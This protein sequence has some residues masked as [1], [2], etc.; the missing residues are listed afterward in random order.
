MNYDDAVQV[1]IIDG[2]RRFLASDAYKAELLTP[3][4]SRIACPLHTRVWRYMKLEYFHRLLNDEQLY[5]PRVDKLGEPLEGSFCTPAGSDDHAEFRRG[6]M[7]QTFYVSCWHIA[8]HESDMMWGRYLNNVDGVAIHTTVGQLLQMR[9][10]AFEWQGY[11]V[12]PAALVGNVRYVDHADLG[13]FPSNDCSLFY[14]DLAFSGDKEF[15]LVFK[16]WSYELQC[17][18]LSE[19]PEY[20]QI[21]FAADQI[22]GVVLK[23]GCTSEILDSVKELAE[24][25]NRKIVVE[26][27][28]LDRVPQW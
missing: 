21:G 25:A 8:E 4:A 11:E 17:A 14:K 12:I 28:R 20:L 13:S 26:R 16:F 3:D 6:F 15:R 18:R 5:V 24:T 2:Q 23:S 27:S 7:Q 9:L 1:K 10:E 22:N 19:R